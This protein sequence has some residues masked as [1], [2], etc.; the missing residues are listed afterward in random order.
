[1]KKSLKEIL[2]DEILYRSKRGF[3]APFGA[4]IKN[5]LN[6]V[7]KNLLSAESIENRGIFNYE[8]IQKSILLHETNKQDYTD[9]LLSLINFEMWARLYI[10]NESINDLIDQLEA[11]VKN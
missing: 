4:W 11:E 6:P 7:L 8:E 3:G 1:M 2:P 9:H 5:E 10:D